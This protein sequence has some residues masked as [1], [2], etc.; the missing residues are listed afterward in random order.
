MHS[1]PLVQLALRILKALDVPEA[2]VTA[3]LI[4]N[5]E[6]DKLASQ[7]F[8][9]LQ[10]QH[11]S[12]QQFRKVA[13]A[14]EFL[15][16]GDFIDTTIDRAAQARAG[17]LACEKQCAV[18]NQRLSKFLDYPVFETKVEHRFSDLL[19]KARAWMRS[20]LGLVPLPLS[21]EVLGPGLKQQQTPVNL[22]GRFGPG[23]VFEKEAWAH[24]TVTQ[25]DKLRNTPHVSGNMDRSLINHLAMDSAMR[26]A[27]NVESPDQFPRVRG[28]RFTTVSK[29]ATKDRGIA[30]EPS[31]NVFGQLAV[32]DLLKTRLLRR[33]IDLRGT[34]T[35][36]HSYTK[37]VFR[38]LELS[39]GC[40]R[41]GQDLHRRE[42]REASRTGSKA[43]I[44]LSN[45][46][47]TVCYNLVKLLLP[48]EWFTLLSSLRSPFT[49]F[50]PT[51]KRKDRRWYRLEKF[52]SMGNG[53]TFELETLIFCALA[54]AVGCQIG[55]DSFVYG[56]DIIVPSDK[57]RD[58]LAI[59]RFCGL[60]PNERKTFVDPGCKFRE[61]CGGDFLDGVDVRPFYIT[62]E[63]IDAAGWIQLA[64]TIREWSLK[65]AIPE[66][67]GAWRHA[68]D[69]IPFAISRLR[70]PKDLGDLVLHD[71]D[72]K[73]WDVIVRSGIR[74]VRVWRPVQ[75]R[76]YLHSLLLKGDDGRRVKDSRGRALREFTEQGVALTAAL[77]GLP[78]TGISPRE[79]VEGFRFGRV[80]FS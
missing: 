28:N 69:Q 22:T 67:L 11:L 23:A 79:S 76:L 34:Y 54:H 80:A 37:D 33:N 78:S 49:L 72:P 64:N 15:R 70:G 41:M 38:E 51:G 77:I 26:F 19:I 31:L 68:I 53:Y 21:S 50:S 58:V 2:Q 14:M 42:A 30:I 6:W 45:A 13:I 27:W 60:T 52:S 71:D 10:Y 3:G 4:K 65:W 1:K 62:E 8:D 48:D 25:Y 7:K 29:D 18:A 75:R 61:S 55:S 32:G 36:F 17:F 43:T 9:P 66:L 12:A 46:S 47:D 35:D 39:F 63:P 40:A 73:T 56:D 5:R 57:A 16:K 20:T 74:Y 24:R 59:L 44:D